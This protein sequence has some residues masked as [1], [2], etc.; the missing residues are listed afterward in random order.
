[1]EKIYKEMGPA[2]CGHPGPDAMAKI[3]DF[4]RA[5]LAPEDVYTFS[6]LLC[7]N[8]VD[9]DFER[10]TEKSLHNLAALFLGTCNVFDHNWSAH[11]QTARI[12]H[13]EVKKEPGVQTEGGEALPLSEGLCLHAA[14][15]QRGAD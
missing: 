5:E 12:Y 6:I 14:R 10:F 7:D 9:R 1:M 2:G 13:T 4:A 8:E 11:G 15:K 3:N